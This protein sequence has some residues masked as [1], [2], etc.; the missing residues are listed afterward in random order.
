MQEDTSGVYFIFTSNDL[1]KF[2][3]ELMDRFEGR[4]FIDL[5]TAEERE[6]ILKIHLRLNSQSEDSLDMPE[7][8]KA[9]KDFSGRNIEQAVE[10]AMNVAF[11]DDRQM[12]QGDLLKVFEDVVPTSKTKAEELRIM[13]QAVENGDMRRANETN[14]S[15]K[16]SGKKGRNIRSFAWSSLL[17]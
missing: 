2:T 1:S 13:R 3:P 11:N 15:K 16:E 4:F 6:E 8:V 9:A 17:N 14:S 12:V 5:P 7:L 10:E